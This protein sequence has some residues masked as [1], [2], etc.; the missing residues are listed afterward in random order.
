VSGNENTNPGKKEAIPMTVGH[1]QPLLELLLPRH[2]NRSSR[3]PIVNAANA[4]EHTMNSPRIASRRGTAEFQKSCI[5][6][7]E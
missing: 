4:I 7:I 3:N 1:I 5:A 2:A 6:S